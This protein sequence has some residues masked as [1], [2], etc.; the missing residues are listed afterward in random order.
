MDRLP[1]LIAMIE[2]WRAGNLIAPTDT[3]GERESDQ[4]SAR[5]A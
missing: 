2:S 4:E 3:T 1:D 5:A